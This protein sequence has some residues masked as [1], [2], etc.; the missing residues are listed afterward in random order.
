VEGRDLV[1][2][3]VPTGPGVNPASCTMG[4]GSLSLQRP[5]REVDHPPSSCGHGYRK[6]RA[7]PLLPLWAFVA[8]YRENFTFTFIDRRDTSATNSVNKL[9]M[10][11]DNHTS[12]QQRCVNVTQE[13]WGL[14]QEMTDMTSNCRLYLCLCGSQNKQRLFHYTILTDW[15][16]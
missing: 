1:T 13:V 6:S 9:A 3:A 16:L 10:S 5:G 12:L 2:A 11:Y 7:I 14:S 4:T 8:C 15:F